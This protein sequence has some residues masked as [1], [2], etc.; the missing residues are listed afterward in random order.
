[1][2]KTRKAQRHISPAIPEWDLDLV[3]SYLTSSKFATTSAETRI[4]QKATFLTL[5]A[6]SRRP[7]DVAGLSLR[8]TN[9]FSCAPNKSVTILFHPTFSPKN[10][11]LITVAEPIQ[12]P[13]LQPHSAALCPIAAIQRYLNITDHKRD[14]GLS[15]LF[16]PIKGTNKKCTPTYISKTTKRLIIEAHR[17]YGEADKSR[18][19]QAKQTRKLAASLAFH[20]GSPLQDVLRAAGWASPSAFIQHYLIRQPLQ[21][22]H[23]AVIGGNSIAP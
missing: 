10:R 17:F 16:L 5:L 14:K 9:N 3:L 12:I 2:K 11:S 23:P 19:T 8:P 13:C 1:M 21:L 22:H 7:S 6:S 18:S 4:F 15:Y 20:A